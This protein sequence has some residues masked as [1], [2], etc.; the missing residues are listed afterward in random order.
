MCYKYKFPQALAR[1]IRYRVQKSIIQSA[2]IHKQYYFLFIN[3]NS[4]IYCFSNE[5][6]I[7]QNIFIIVW[8]RIFGIA[9]GNGESIRSAKLPLSLLTKGAGLPCYVHLVSGTSLLHSLRERTYLLHSPRGQDPLLVHSVPRISLLHSPKGQD[10]PVTFTYWTGIC[11][12]IHPR[13]RTTQLHSLN[14]V[15]GQDYAVT[16]TQGAGLPCIIYPMGRI[17]GNIHRRDSTTLSKSPKGHDCPVT[18]T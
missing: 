15:N 13:D 5:R 10:F 6:K 3:P 2:K 16:F 12:Y 11:G 1:L 4:K 8:K 7:K 9:S 14:Q 17:P 18:F